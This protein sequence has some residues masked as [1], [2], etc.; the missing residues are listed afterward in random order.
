MARERNEDGYTALRESRDERGP[1]PLGR[2]RGGIA[3]ASFVLS[4]FPSL[5]LSPRPIQLRGKDKE[6]RVSRSAP[7]NGNPPSV[8]ACSG[9]PSLSSLSARTILWESGSKGI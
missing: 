2:F 9:D 6:A 5:S 7:L 1:S 3:V 4:L 8:L